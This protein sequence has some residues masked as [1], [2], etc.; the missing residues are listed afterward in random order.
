[1]RFFNAVPGIKKLVAALLKSI[2]ELLTVVVF[3]SFLFFLY[4]VI[5]VQLW[6]GV[7]HSRCRLTPYP[8]HLDPQLTF[9][10]LP[11]YQALI[12]ENHSLHQCRDENNDVVSIEDASWTHDSS[13]W[14]VPKV[15]FWP[16]A[17][18]SRPQLCNLNGDNREC[19]N[20]QVRPLVK[21]I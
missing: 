5:G 17:T 10:E 1:M 7:M 14:R 19:P 12:A 4:G 13:P 16:V 11:A 20:G 18:E 2:P 3:L 6:S 21:P 9:E 15:C 8:V